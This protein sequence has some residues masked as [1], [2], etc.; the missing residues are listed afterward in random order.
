MEEVSNG[1]IVQTKIVWGMN[2]KYPRGNAAG[3]PIVADFADDFGNRLITSFSDDEVSDA[4]LFRSTIIYLW[5]DWLAIRSDFD[6]KQ[7]IE[8]RH[9]SNP[10]RSFAE[11]TTDKVVSA[12]LELA[13][14]GRKSLVC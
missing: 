6:I 9:G 12:G 7:L 14:I 4:R 10:G 8:K 11:R 5:G 3:V 2:P 13:K 1:T